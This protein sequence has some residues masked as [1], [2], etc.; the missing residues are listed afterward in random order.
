M[1]V[2]GPA[3]G[4]WSAAAASAE[5]SCPLKAPFSR[6]L[7]IPEANLLHRGHITLGADQVDLYPV[8][9][10]PIGSDCPRCLEGP[11]ARGGQAPDRLARQRFDGC[12][13]VGPGPPRR[14]I[15]RAGDPCPLDLAD[16]GLD[17]P[18]P[19]A[20]VR[21]IHPV[22]AFAGGLRREG[23]RRRDDPFRG[24]GGE[25]PAGHREVV[26]PDARPCRKTPMRHL[27]GSEDRQD[28][29]C[30]RA[31]REL[32]GQDPLPDPDEV[33]IRFCECR[34]RRKS[35]SVPPANAPASRGESA[36]HQVGIDRIGAGAS[37][38]ARR[39]QWAQRRDH[40]LARRPLVKRRTVGSQAFHHREVRPDEDD[41]DRALLS[42]RHAAR[43][44]PSCGLNAGEPSGFRRR[45][46]SSGN[47]SITMMLG[48]SGEA[49]ADAERS[50]A[51]QSPYVAPAAASGAAGGRTQL[52]ARGI[53]RVRASR[54]SR[55]RRRTGSAPGTAAELGHEPA[56]AD[57][58]TA[59]DRHQAPTTGPGLIDLP[60]K[61]TELPSARP[62]KPCMPVSALSTT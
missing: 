24:Q 12:S 15:W 13:S 7:L 38:D 34:F 4:T 3:P 53:A 58:T 16:R 40:H 31:G 48:R 35:S 2:D 14:S 8:A 6:H 52:V 44:L 23:Q 49:S 60:V 5:A 47:S 56:L 39:L 55:G 32:R 57:L 20:Q 61:L 28:R 10:G 42:V 54:C 37:G 50:A 33:R 9:P 30:T 27:A 46:Q 43:T 21:V 19:E 36:V 18:E 17:E 11:V 1:R 26:R 41:H 25:W 29:A 51:S 62:M 59:P 22:P 45:S